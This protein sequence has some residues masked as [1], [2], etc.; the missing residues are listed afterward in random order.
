MQQLLWIRASVS[1]FC[2]C[3]HQIHRVLLR[4]LFPVDV[5]I[6]LEKLL[7]NKT[8]KC[9]SYSLKTTV[10]MC[11]CQV[12]DKG[13]CYQFRQQDIGE[14]G[15]ENND[16]GCDE[17]TKCCIMKLRSTYRRGQRIIYNFYDF[18]FFQLQP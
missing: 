6:K 1:L 8:I 11:V 12:C 10:I 2:T 16:T 9:S 14:E 18:T 17:V 3:V 15:Q 4:S 7:K 5:L 13:V